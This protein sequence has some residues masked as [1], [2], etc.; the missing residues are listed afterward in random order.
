LNALKKFSNENEWQ[1]IDKQLYIF[2]SF[3]KMNKFL[4]FA[5]KSQNLLMAALGQIAI[6]NLDKDLKQFRELIELDLCS[7]QDLNYLK[8]IGVFQELEINELIH[9]RF[10]ELENKY[11]HLLKSN[12]GLKLK[13]EGLLADYNRAKTFFSPF[14]TGQSP[15]TVGCRLYSC[16]DNKFTPNRN[17]TFK[18]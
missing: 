11:K 3:E 5:I 6:N 13:F 12:R 18:Y 17:F 1:I 9:N 8:T 10:E 2:D 4:G 16:N 15:V 14:I 7:V